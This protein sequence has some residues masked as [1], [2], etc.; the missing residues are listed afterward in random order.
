[1]G[2]LKGQFEKSDGILMQFVLWSKTIKLL[3][4][5]SRQEPVVEAWDRQ[6]GP[7][8]FLLI[9]SFSKSG[10]G[11]QFRRAIE[12]GRTT[13]SRFGYRFQVHVDQLLQFCTVL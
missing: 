11:W 7:E 10:D 2:Q 5:V 13:V 6:L 3:L 1:M 8:A 4:K 9:R 12:P